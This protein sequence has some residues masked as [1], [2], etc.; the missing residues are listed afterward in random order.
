MNSYPRYIF[1]A[2]ILLLIPHASVAVNGY[3]SPGARSAALAG[4]SVALSGVEGLFMNQAS[5]GF[6]N[7]VSLMLNYESRFMLSE[8][9]FMSAGI[10]LPLPDICFGA[11]YRQSGTGVYKE[12][13]AGLAAAKRFGRHLSAGL[14]FNYLNVRIPEDPDNV[15]AFS[16]EGGLLW[17]LAENFSMGVHYTHPFSQGDPSGMTDV[18]GFRI[19]ECW[20]ISEMV[21]WTCDLEKQKAMSWL[22]KSGLEFRPVRSLFLR[23]GIRGF[24][25]HPSGGVG[26]RFSNYS[27]DLAFSYFANLGFSPSASLTFGL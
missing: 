3:F 1:L 24:P 15:Q 25:F 5:L 18:P 22:L 8:Y 10:V 23:M 16:F 7:Q 11:G 13:Q 26:F 6:E 4:S 12:A 9:S 20:H 17:H 19:G 2:A 27:F 14:Q 21:S